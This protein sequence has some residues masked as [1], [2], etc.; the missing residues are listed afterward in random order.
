MK[1]LEH[2]KIM[3]IAGLLFI[4]VI[5][6]LPVFYTLFYHSLTGM[7]TANNGSINL[8]HVTS[9]HRIILDG[10]WEF[11]WNRLLVTEPQQDNRPDFLIR[12]SDYWSK[13]QLNG[14]FLPAAGFASY[15]LKIKEWNTSRPVT[16]Y[17]PDFG[18]AYRVFVDGKLTAKSGVVSKQVPCIFTTPRAQIY[19]ISLSKAPEHEVVV[20]VATTRFSGLYMSPVLMDYTKAIRGDNN[21]NNVR[22]I[23]FGVALFSFLVLILAY[24]LSRKEK[25]N[26]IWLPIMGTF[27]LMRIMLTTEFYSFW[28]DPVFFHLSY[29]AINPLMFL[30]S[31]TF[32]YLLIYLVQELLGIA[33]S[34]K[35]KLGFLV[36]YAVIFFIYLFLP[37]GIYNRHLTILIPLCT[38]ALEIY[39]FC[40]IYRNRNQLKKHG[41]LIYWGA[42]L[43]IT[44][45]IIDSYYING[46]IYPN[47]SLTLL[48][49]LTVYLILLSLVS[50]MRIGD[51]YQEFTIASS[52]L[53]QARTQI[54][55]QKEYYDALSLQMNEIRSIRHDMHHFVGVL[56]RLSEEKR[57]EELNEFLGE[58]A[59]KAE[60]EPLPVFCEN[61]VANSILGYYS[62]RLKELGIP[63]RCSVSIPKQLWV[64]DG[65]ICVILGNALDNAIEACDRLNDRKDRFIAVE[66]RNVKGQLLVK[67]QNSYNGILIKKG[68]HYHTTKESSHHGIGLGNIHKVAEAYGGFVRI[69]HT[70]EV[71]T[72]MAAFRNPENGRNVINNKSAE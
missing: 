39:L 63:F 43:A 50:A 20:E 35:E 5:S 28:Q 37:Y 15:R 16:I 18:S 56:R 33:F 57:Y 36:Y 8:S 60:M 55:M 24:I 66:V 7:P 4:T 41:L 47:M 23:L 68:S 17:L 29:E 6:H 14:K 30:I 2:N 70:M 72:L 11:Y 62:L 58:Y 59:E 10:K 48:I 42:I 34:K 38:Y 40:K 51:M 19:P 32:K 67:V 26:S 3:V 46:N 65:D 31:F 1:R 44:G 54:N 21:R 61:I 71:F 53:S 12:V 52:Y 69:E 9:D 13:Y 49:L 22:L 64:S 45:L 25:K 27:V